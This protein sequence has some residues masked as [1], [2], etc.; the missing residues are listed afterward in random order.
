MSPQPLADR[1]DRLEKRVSVLEQI[2][3]RLD[4][5]E[6]QILLLRTEMREEFLAVRTEIHAGDAALGEEIRT[7]DAALHEEI[8]ACDA[9]LRGEIRSGD[10]ETRRLMRVLHEEVLERIARIGE[11]QASRGQSRRPKAPRS[12]E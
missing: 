3:A 8:R 4:S 2:P 6:S 5:L 11:G 10:E 1:V 9:A 12:N 7:G